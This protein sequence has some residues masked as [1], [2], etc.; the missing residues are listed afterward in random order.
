[1]QI[2]LNV[3]AL[4]VR[5]MSGVLALFASV[6]P[7]VLEKAISDLSDGSTITDA[8]RVFATAP[9]PELPG[10]EVEEQTHTDASAAPAEPPPAAPDTPPAAPAAA[11]APAPVLTGSAVLDKEGLP[12][13]G[14]IH[15][16]VEGGGGK[17]TKD[18]LWRAKRNV[19]ADTRAAVVAELKA[20]LAAA[21]APA[22]PVPPAP[23]APAAA[24]P[25]PSAPANPAPSA[26]PAPSAP[27]P[28][29]APVAP[30]PA[31][32]P[33][34]V[35]DTGAAPAPAAEFARL[36]GKVTAAQTAGKVTAEE[37]TACL[38][39]LGLSQLRDLLTRP[40]LV[41]AFEATVDAMIG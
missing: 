28:P 26:E 27:P 29:A 33:A 31:P 12:W 36:M 22:A 19:P 17:I 1:M 8:A 30:A 11:P 4:T 3:A 6:C 13:D 14:R 7:D 2:T 41:P 35:A 20:A 21:P 24:P 10:H 32:A 16:T 18:G 9:M 40:D 25:P 34:P 37:V 39:G 38:G 23:A 5:E 15:A